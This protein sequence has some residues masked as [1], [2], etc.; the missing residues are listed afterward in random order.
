V[1]V[2]GETMKKCSSCKVE[3]ELSEFYRKSS[4]KDGLNCFCKTCDLLKRKQYRES[5]SELEKERKRDYYHQNAEKIKNKV[6]LYYANNSE[7]VKEYQKVY[8]EMNAQKVSERHKEYYDK[9]KLKLRRD[10]KDYYN[11]NVAKFIANVAKRN[12]AKLKATPSWLTQEQLDEI[13]DFY[14]IAR[15]FK[16]YTGEDYHVDHVVPLQGKKVCGLHV[17]WNLQVLHGKDNLRKS[18]KL[19]ELNQQGAGYTDRHGT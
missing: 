11:K 2:S 3:K 8:N 15:M 16:M 5:N 4:S 19:Q 1:D 10:G 17:P 12:A 18:N 7:K 14:T 6:K 9:N 13:A